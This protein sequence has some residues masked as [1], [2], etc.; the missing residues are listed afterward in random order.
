MA[1]NQQPRVVTT[2]CVFVEIMTGLGQ[3]GGN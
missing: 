1:F 3:M 2:A